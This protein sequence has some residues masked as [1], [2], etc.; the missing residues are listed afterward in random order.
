MTLGPGPRNYIWATCDQ[1][2]YEA[3]RLNVQHDKRTM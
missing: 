3:L 1:K 2:T